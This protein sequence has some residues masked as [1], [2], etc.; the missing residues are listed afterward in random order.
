MCDLSES[1]YVNFY[2]HEGTVIMDNLEADK[3]QEMKSNGNRDE[4]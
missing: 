2:R 4:L 1:L 3:M